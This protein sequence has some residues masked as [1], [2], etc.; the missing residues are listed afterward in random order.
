MP[1]E[2]RHPG[3]GQNPDGLRCLQSASSQ[4]SWGPRG[5]TWWAAGSLYLKDSASSSSLMLYSPSSRA[6]GANTCA[7]HRQIAPTRRTRCDLMSLAARPAA[8]SRRRSSEHARCAADCLEAAGLGAAHLQRFVGD[9]L[10]L[11]GRHGAQGAHVV[12][13]VRQLH[14]DDPHLQPRHHTAP[15]SGL[16][17]AFTCDAPLPLDTSRAGVSR[18]GVWEPSPTSPQLQRLV[19]A[20]AR[21]ELQF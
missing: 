12:Q 2:E 20:T 11:M 1:K 15:I 9:L 13:T 6:R 17:T 3:A 8:P 21:V 5:G 10:L 16:S 4:G 7:H 19:T 18:A 14:Y